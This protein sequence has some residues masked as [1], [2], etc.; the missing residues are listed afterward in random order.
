MVRPTPA[1]ASRETA[2][3]GLKR[4]PAI[5]GM[6]RGQLA[7]QKRPV[8]AGRELHQQDEAASSGDLLVCRQQHGRHEDQRQDDAEPDGHNEKFFLA[9]DVGSVSRWNS[10]CPAKTA[11]ETPLGCD[12][13]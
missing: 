8:G 5:E 3:N 11:P 6:T 7:A 1:S 13:F 12:T 2:L 10:L 9:H 4:T